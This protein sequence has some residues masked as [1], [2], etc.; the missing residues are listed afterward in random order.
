[1]L[2]LENIYFCNYSIG[3]QVYGE[4]PAVCSMYGKKILLIGGEK[5]L[6][7]GKV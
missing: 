3:E 5:A 4:V 6:A 2:G 1:M 7:A